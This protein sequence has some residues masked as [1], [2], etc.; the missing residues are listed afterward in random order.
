MILLIAETW[1]ILGLHYTKVKK[2]LSQT[3][4]S[5]LRLTGYVDRVVLKSTLGRYLPGLR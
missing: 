4:N 3:C 1:F 5:Y 2:V